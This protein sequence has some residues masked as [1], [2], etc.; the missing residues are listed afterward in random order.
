MADRADKFKNTAFLALL[1]HNEDKNGTIA[2]IQGKKPA[3]SVTRGLYYRG[4]C[5]NI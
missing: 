2:A 5:E 4:V 1:L 3:D